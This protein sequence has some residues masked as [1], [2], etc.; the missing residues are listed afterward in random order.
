M[1][2]QVERR[3]AQEV[4][5]GIRDGQVLGQPAGLGGDRAARFQGV[6]EGVA[7][8]GHIGT[9]A[10]IPLGRRHFGDPVDNG[11]GYGF[12]PVGHG[13]S[14]ERSERRGKASNRRGRLNCGA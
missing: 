2:L 4:A 5:L 3:G 1:V 7:H 13:P 11:D 8:E 10:G 14:L 12:A 6:Q 9:G